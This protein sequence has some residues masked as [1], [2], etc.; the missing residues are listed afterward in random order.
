MN[1]QAN[2]SRPLETA[3]EQ[4]D[5]LVEAEALKNLLTQAATQATRLTA[6]LRGFRRQQKAVQSVVN[7]LKS[8]NP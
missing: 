5:V 6:A 2:G 1:P 8:I 4:S 7:T 3:A